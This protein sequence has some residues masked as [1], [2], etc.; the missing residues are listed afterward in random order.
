MIFVSDGFLDK[1]S[2]KDTKTVRDARVMTG[3]KHSLDI[4]RKKQRRNYNSEVSC[5]YCVS[6]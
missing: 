1:N 3:T 6:Y 5:C 4:V 2:F